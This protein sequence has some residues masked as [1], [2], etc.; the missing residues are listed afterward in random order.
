ML[1]EPCSAYTHVQT[2]V[3]HYNVFHLTLFYLLTLSE[4][5]K[6]LNY[7]MILQSFFPQSHV[8]KALLTLILKDI[9]RKAIVSQIL[10]HSVC[11]VALRIRK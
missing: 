3:V 9:E 4:L 2:I 11:T 8:N 10:L 5:H 1:F 7:F 6:D